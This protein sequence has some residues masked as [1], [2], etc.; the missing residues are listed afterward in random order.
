MH[1]NK[2]NIRLFFILG[3]LIVLSSTSYGGDLKM[4]N[5]VVKQLQIESDRLKMKYKKQIIAEQEALKI[6]T[7]YLKTKEYNYKIDWENPSIR[8]EQ[9]TLKKDGS[10]SSGFGKKI[11]IW[12]VWFLPLQGTDLGKGITKVDADIDAKTGEVF[13]K[14]NLEKL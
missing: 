3:V 1:I 8:L 14:Y 2:I 10:L 12:H 11:L 5:N 13:T 6:A 4:K 9:R 7:V